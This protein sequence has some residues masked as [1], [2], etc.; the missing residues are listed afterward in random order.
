LSHTEALVAVTR[1]ESAKTDGEIRE[2]SKQFMGFKWGLGFGVSVD[3]EEGDR[4]DS[5]EVVGDRV[6]VT[7]DTSVLPRIVLEGHH[8][9]FHNGPRVSGG[10]D[11]DGAT[12]GQGPFIAVQSSGDEV[13][14]G[15]GLGWMVGFRYKTNSPSSFNLALGLMV[16]A[17]V[18]TLGEGI[19]ANK[20]LPGDETTARFKEES[21]TGL[22]LFGSFSF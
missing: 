11:I 20:P 9:V 4:V 22:L 2:A 3:L 21:R 18:K 16:D 14:S 7:K 10:R 6:R 1:I 19:E 17:N 13:I 8:F 15:F 12:R 5:A